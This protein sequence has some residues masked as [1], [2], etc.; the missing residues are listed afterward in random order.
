[1]NSRGDILLG[2]FR[3]SDAVLRLGRVELPSQRAFQTSDNL[4]AMLT[5]DDHDG[6]LEVFDSGFP[7]LAVL[8]FSTSNLHPVSTV[9]VARLDKAGGALCRSVASWPRRDRERQ[10]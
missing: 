8:S 9:G 4:P 5:I 7:P 1:M 10:D 6:A 2:L 3:I